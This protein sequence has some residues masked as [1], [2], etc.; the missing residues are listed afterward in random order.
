MAWTPHPGLIWVGHDSG[1]GNMGDVTDETSVARFTYPGGKKFVPIF[2]RVHFAG[3][4][5]GTANLA[6]RIDSRLG[7]HYDITLHTVSAR[8]AGA[9]MFF[10]VERDEYEKWVLQ[11]GDYSVLEWTNPDGSGNLTW[12]AEMGL[13]NAED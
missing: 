1:T 5:S 8:G 10:R 7:D 2:I 11:P 3:T 6:V 13:A 4:G 9:D 12:G